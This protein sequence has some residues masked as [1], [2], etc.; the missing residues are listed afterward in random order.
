[1]AKTKTQFT[2][3][4]VQSFIEDYVDNEQKK[5]DSYKLIELLEEWS[6]Y[7]AQMFGPT[8]VG[9]GVYD[10]VYES[11][12][13]GS[14]PILGFSPR[15]AA[16]SLYVYSNTEKS[17]EALNNFGKFKMGKACIYVKKLSDIN[18]DALKVL[19]MESIKYIETHHQCSCRD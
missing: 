3:Q 10:Y 2:S 19:C 12:H 5:I 1:M 7:K 4:N 15:K 8:I 6:G 14:A 17:N 18:L 13:S 16:F 9:F 11:G